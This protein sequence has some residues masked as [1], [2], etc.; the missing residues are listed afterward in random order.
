MVRGA[1]QPG[2]PRSR[3]WRGRFAQCPGTPWAK[4]P[5]PQ[6]DDLWGTVS[7]HHPHLAV[8]LRYRSHLCLF[9]C[10]GPWSKEFKEEGTGSEV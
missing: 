6:C 4:Q 10:R 3:V 2:T 7:E 9:T 5:Q 8:S 1:S